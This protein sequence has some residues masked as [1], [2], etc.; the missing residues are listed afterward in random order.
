MGGG[1]FVYIIHPNE[2]LAFSQRV[3]H[4]WERHLTKFLESVGKPSQVKGWQQ[5]KMLEYL[6]CVTRNDAE[7]TTSARELFEILSHLRAK[8][9]AANQCGLFQDRRT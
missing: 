5:K 8:A 6:M 1:H 2:S 9:S 4:V 3:E 7:T